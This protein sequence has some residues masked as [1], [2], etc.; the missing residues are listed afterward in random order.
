MK[1]QF[2]RQTGTL[3]RS[4]VMIL[5]MPCCES[6]IIRIDIRIAK[7][8]VIQ[9][10]RQGVSIEWIQTEAAHRGQSRFESWDMDMCLVDSH[11][12]EMKSVGK[13]IECAAYSHAFTPDFDLILSR[14]AI[15]NSRLF[16]LRMLRHFCHLHDK[17]TLLV[18][19]DDFSVCRKKTDLMTLDESGTSV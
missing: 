3:C 4:T 8:P 10:A 14:A 16:R 6:A 7:H 17:Q 9:S 11:R 15:V 5:D 2:N 1:S 18:S 13:D 19:E 12:F